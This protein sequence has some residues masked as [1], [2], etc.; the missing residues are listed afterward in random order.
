MGEVAPMRKKD[1]RKIFKTTDGYFT[2]RADIKKPRRVA[3]IDQRRDDGALAVVK[4]Y[5]AKGKGGRRFV[6]KLILTPE[7]HSSLKEDSLV[8]NRVYLGIKTKDEKGQDTY[9]PIFRSDLESTDDKLKQSE[10]QK[11]KKG[12]KGITKQQQKNH[13]DRMRKWHKHF[14]DK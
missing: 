9:K 4:I 2:D 14:K 7:K 12:T 1:K 3:A 13:R 6:E 8:G 5:S 11:I 10:Y